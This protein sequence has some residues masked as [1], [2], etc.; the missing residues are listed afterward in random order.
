MFFG[1][2]AD[3]SEMHADL[4]PEKD[5]SKIAEYFDKLSISN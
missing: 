4:I 2:V 1:L 3:V 5:Q